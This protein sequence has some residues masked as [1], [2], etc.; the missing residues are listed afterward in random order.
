MSHLVLSGPTLRWAVTMLFGVSIAAD[1]YVFGEQR[2]RWIRAL[3]HL[4]H[5]TMSAAMIAMAWHIGA[6]LPG[7]APIVFFLLGGAWFVVVAVR[8]C[9]ALRDRI[10]SCYNAA[11]MIAMAW[12]YAVMSGGLS[13]RAD[14]SA[15][16]MQS[17]ADAAPM[18]GM[19]MQQS[20]P[21]PDT[22]ITTV[23]WI[24]TAGFAL[25]AMHWFWLCLYRP[26]AGSGTDQ[27][28][29]TVRLTRLRLLSQALAA[30]GTA[31]MFSATL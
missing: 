5:V 18:A 19:A 29:S 13:G 25:A 4:L 9:G 2:P 3:D 12:M 28:P 11:M 30:A 17:G 21:G 16:R 7:Y 31:V 24:V 22:W 8:R 10:V 1:V 23:D 6:N 26:V 27:S 14:P 15:G 20:A